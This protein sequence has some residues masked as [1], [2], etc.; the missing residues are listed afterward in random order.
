MT[1]FLLTASG[2]GLCMGITMLIASLPFRPLLAR[3]PPTI[4]R[5]SSVH[6][7][8]SSQTLFCA[9]HSVCCTSPTNICSVLSSYTCSLVVVFFMFCQN[10]THMC[11]YRTESQNTTGEHS[12][13]SEVFS[14]RS[15]S[16]ATSVAPPTK[17]DWGTNTLRLRGSLSE[18]SPTRRD[19]LRRHP[20]FPTSQNVKKNKFSV[21]F[22]PLCVGKKFKL[23]KIRERFFCIG[24]L[25]FYNK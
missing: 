7:P 3:L 17:H 24:G 13:G 15:V 19:P 18:V 9:C 8:Q 4:T 5:T 16:D 21:K 2:P 6:I 1:V 10:T 14:L 25:S 20:C 11:C 12:S 23:Q 22:Y